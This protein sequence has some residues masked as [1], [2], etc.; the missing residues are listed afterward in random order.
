MTFLLLLSE[1]DGTL[2]ITSVGCP[3]DSV[4]G[5]VQAALARGYGAVYV[6]DREVPPPVATQHYLAEGTLAT[7]PG[8]TDYFFAES[9]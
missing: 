7:L 4:E 5:T 8:I 3:R 6:V 2:R 9:E 1:V